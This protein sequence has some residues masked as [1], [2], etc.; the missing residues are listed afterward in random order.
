MN[1]GHEIQKT[2]APTWE[3]RKRNSQ[4]DGEER[5]QSTVIHQIQKTVSL[6]TEAGQKAPGKNQQDETAYLM[7]LNAGSNGEKFS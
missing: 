6:E 4:D 7:K 5:S 2:R 3:K 1:T